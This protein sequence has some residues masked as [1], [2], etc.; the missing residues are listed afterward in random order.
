LQILRT[1]VA[2]REGVDH[3]SLN[4]AR[5]DPRAGWRKPVAHARTG[6]RRPARINE[7]LAKGREPT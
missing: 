1:I 7:T 5:I 4:L 6:H 3:A 2:Q